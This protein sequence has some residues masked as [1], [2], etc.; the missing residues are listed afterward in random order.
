VSD[1]VSSIIWTLDAGWGRPSSFFLNA[2]SGV[3]A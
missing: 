3:E 2:G 1:A